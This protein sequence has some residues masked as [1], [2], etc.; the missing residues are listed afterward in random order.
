MILVSPSNALCIPSDLLECKVRLCFKIKLNIY[1]SEYSP[2]YRRV[3]LCLVGI[4]HMVYRICKVIRISIPHSP[5][6]CHAGPEGSRKLRLLD[7]LT[8]AQYGGSLS[9]LHTDRLYPQGYSWFSFSLGAESTPGPRFGR[10][11]ICH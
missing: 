3:C 4:L 2:V 10:K 9:A 11:E 1:D 5:I 6:T 8:M 7:F